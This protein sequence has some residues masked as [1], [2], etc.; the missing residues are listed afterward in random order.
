MHEDKLADHG[1]NKFT[2]P[3]GLA[4]SLLRF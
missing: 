1:V 2:L 3:K 4:K